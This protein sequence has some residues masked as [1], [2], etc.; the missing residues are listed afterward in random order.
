MN[1]F[2][3]IE[4]RVKTIYKM[5]STIAKS[6]AAGYSIDW[7]NK[8]VSNGIDTYKLNSQQIAEFTLC[9]FFTRFSKSEKDITDNILINGYS[10][11]IIAGESTNKTVEQK[12]IENVYDL[13]LDT[14][15]ELMPEAISLT[16]PVDIIAIGSLVSTIETK[17]VKLSANA[18]L[19]HKFKLLEYLPKAA[20]NVIEE[21]ETRLDAI[22]V[23]E[24]YT[25]LVRKYIGLAEL[26]R[27]DN[28]ILYYIMKNVDN[29][30]RVK[31][32]IESSKDRGFSFISATADQKTFTFDIEFSL[33]TDIVQENL[34]LDGSE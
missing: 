25:S 23:N 2:K 33:D 6:L 5:N 28:G 29:A 30:P 13:G 24:R 12:T 10:D 14:F 27:C 16:V 22:R 31:K 3:Q 20:S 11:T 18:E 7:E 8:T 34:N 17:T 26:I 15:K 32:L 21:L 4:N 1:T 19:I 9:H